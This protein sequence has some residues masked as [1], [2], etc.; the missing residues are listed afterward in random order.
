MDA[1][2]WDERYADRELV[3]SA[4]PNRFLVEQTQGM[5]TGRALD[6]AAGE[7]R[8]SIWLAQQ[9]WAVTA[10][11]FSQVAIDK[12]R[13]RA[14]AA[15]LAIEWV[16][17]DVTTW[18]PPDR[19]FDLV[20]VF[21]LQL[22]QADGRAAHR[23]AASAVASGGTLLVVGHDLDNLTEGYGGPQDPE[24]LLSADA[25]VEDLSTTGLT[26]ESAGQVPRTVPTDDGERTAIDL[27][28][29]A[30]RR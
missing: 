10:A 9:G 14:A 4:G 26:I 25:V 18:E 24:V 13:Q 19:A 6:I 21:Y 17:A 2:R 15:G 5:Q 16:V 3:W 30:T 27:L 22:P 7:G 12:G 29:R 8:N 20:I 1:A 11:D 23:H 28:V